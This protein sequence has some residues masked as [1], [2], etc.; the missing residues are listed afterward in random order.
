MP[1]VS[2]QGHNPTHER[3]AW[4]ARFNSRLNRFRNLLFSKW[5]IP[6][7]TVVA[8]LGVEGILWRLEKPMFV[9]MGRMI[10]GIKIAV[11]EASVYNEELSNFLGTQQAL[12]YSTIVRQKA[13][14]RLG[15]TKPE[16]KAAFLKVVILPKT[17]VFV[18]TATGEDPEDTQSFLQALMEEFILYKSQMR[19]KTSSQTVQGLTEEVIRLEKDLANAE[20]EL[21][22]FRSTNSVVLSQESG[23]SAAN[24]LAAL[25]QK[26]ASLKSEH[27]LLQLL[28]LD[29]NLERRQQA[30][31]LLPLA[32]A[33]SAEKVSNN[34][35]DRG[36]TEYFKAKQQLLLLKAEQKE[37]AQ[38][39]RPKHPKMVALAEDIARRERLLEIFRQQSAEQL[40]SK[41]SSLALQ[42]QNLER[43]V[44]D[45]DTKTLEIS[46]K[47]AEEQRLKGNVQR[48]QA[49]YERL[50]STMKTVETSAPISPESVSISENAS[51]AVA[52]KESLSHKALVGGLAGLAVGLLL[53]LILDRLDDRMNSF[54]ELQDLFD[55]SVLGQIPREKTGKE[56]GSAALM[57]GPEDSRHAFVEAYRNLRSSLLYIAESGTRPR[58]IIITSSVPSEGKSLTSANLAITLANSGS[59]VLLVD[60]DLRKGVLHN[61]FGVAVEPGL[62][63]VLAQG[64]TAEET[65]QPTRFA[66]LQILPRGAVTHR[67]SELFIHPSS[68]K[69]L[70]DT[71]A[72]FD[73]VLIDTAPVM[74]ADDVTSLAPNMD[75][76]IFVVRADY[77]SARLARAALD[78]LYQRQVKVI[79]LVFNAVR[80]TTLDYYYYKYQDY[81]AAY[82]TA[83]AAAKSG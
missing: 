67:S 56:A 36:D 41:K 64:M 1:E 54:T 60:G 24:Y 9:S 39:L 46:R 35:G 50:S 48:L 16:A 10:M 80:P 12:M 66:N 33:D 45:W 23:N 29:Q 58:T 37:L 76:T 13:V 5:W 11:S 21:A 30:G 78:L 18:L 65:I 22:S 47:M 51:L 74:A 61:L 69:F 71:A 59:R 32:P 7:L 62:T 31:D 40:E 72:Q 34:A 20:S 6:L 83:G 52:T 79:G 14:E 53:L 42:I 4:R 82:P 44:K 43:D 73:Y 38:D 27:E 49:V 26:L 77:T 19:A 2:E 25:N 17:T 3:H 63:E 75:G 8:G 81:Y 57:V 55:E 70:K 15:A 68:A 28:T